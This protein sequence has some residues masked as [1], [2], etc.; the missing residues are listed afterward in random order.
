MPRKEIRLSHSWE[1][2]LGNKTPEEAL[3]GGDSFYP[4]QVPHDWSMDYPFDKDAECGGAGGYVKTGVGWYR[5]KLDINPADK[6][7]VFYLRFDGV[8]MDSTVYLNGKKIGGH[9]YG[10][11]P[12][13]IDISEYIDFDAENILCVK[14]DNSAQP[15]SRWYSGSG[16]TRD[17]WL[18]ALNPIH[19]AEYGIFAKTVSVSK[20]S[21]VVEVMTEIEGPEVARSINVR[22]VMRTADS[23]QVNVYGLGRGVVVDGKAQV[24]HTVGVPRPRL[25]SVDDPYLYS[26][27]VSL[28]SGDELL[29]EKTIRFG[30]REI[31]W[32]PDKGFILNGKQTKLL[33]GCIHHDGGGVGAAVP[34]KV[35]KRRLEKLKLMGMNALRMAHNPPDPALLDLCDEMGFLVMDEVFDEWTIVKDTKAFMA[36]DKISHGYGEHFFEN[37]REDT[38]M[39]IRR[40]RNHPSIV[41]WSV[42]NEVVEQISLDGHL[43]AKE[44]VEICHNLDDTRPVTVGCDFIAAEPIG[45][46][47]EFLNA[48]DV[49]GYNYP[50]RWRER[51][52]TFYDIDKMKHP[53]WIFIGTETGGV[54]GGIRGEYTFEVPSLK[55]GETPLALL[56]KPAPYW[57]NQVTAERQI[58]YFMTRDFVAGDFMWTAIDHLGECRWP[59]V[60]APVGLLDTCGFEKDNYWFYKS[61]WRKDEPFVYVLPHWSLNLEH[62][63]II[64]V[65]AYTSC[66]EVELFLNGKSYGV[67]SY[68]FPAYG[69]AIT[70]FGMQKIKNYTTDDLHLSWDVPYEPGIIEVVGYIDGE[71]VARCV[72]KTVSEPVKLDIST[73]EEPKMQP[74]GMDI[75]QIEISALDKDGNF[76]PYADTNIHV[77]V[78]GAGTLL[79]FDNGD[80]RD[81]S[82]YRTNEKRLFNGRALLT[83]RSKQEAGVCTVSVTGTDMETQVLQIEVY[84]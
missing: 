37:Y 32:T 50:D 31:E 26:I 65:I 57:L 56:G 55:K 6:D 66:E 51:S 79:A 69:R 38:E 14:V 10:Y 3:H 2:S 23:K 11:T 67:K 82:G 41:I 24:S 71:E 62:G 9:Y 22:T 42:G 18:V 43:I 84:E 54:R 72:R 60:T 8:Y 73:Y 15:N 4:V 46:Y 45:T 33:G 75:V 78:E 52:A 36:Q 77:D 68:E 21:A 70:Q 64:P 49:V 16:I 28:Y 58:K 47:E 81:S 80:P 34:I 1:F 35:W 30:I 39:F 12:F 61:I 27:T 59:R 74:D 53:E 44:L 13:T 17:V 48:L 25:W 5:R 19:I 63:R 29:D 20:N 40:D 83:I 76:V 7:K